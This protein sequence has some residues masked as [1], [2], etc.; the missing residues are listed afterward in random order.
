MFVSP[1]VYLCWDIY[2]LILE[3]RSSS[4]T[5]S[6]EK[7]HETMTTV[8]H[9]DPV[10]GPLIRETLGMTKARALLSSCQEVAVLHRE[11]DFEVT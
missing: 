2:I 4:L 7:N 11:D 10:R 5:E 8:P 9:E 6:K 3:R 1:M